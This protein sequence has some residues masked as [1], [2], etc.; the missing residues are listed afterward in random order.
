MINFD[1]PGKSHDVVTRMISYQKLV[2]KFHT[3]EF[4]MNGR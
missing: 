3:E 2:L 1:I 4:M